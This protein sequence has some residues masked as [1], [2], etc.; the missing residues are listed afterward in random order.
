MPAVFPPWSNAAFRIGIG[1]VAIT[2]AG[3]PCGLW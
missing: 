2:V 3:I 1:V